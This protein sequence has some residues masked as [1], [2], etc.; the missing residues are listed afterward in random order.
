MN[1]TAQRFIDH[2]VVTDT[3]TGLAWTKTT[4]AKDV[5]YEQAEKAVAALGEGWRL[6]TADELSTLVDR[7][8]HEPAI[9]TDAFPDTQ[10]DIYWTSTPCAWNPEAAVWVVGFDLG[11]VNVLRRGFVGCVRAVRASQ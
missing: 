5:T 8:R 9:D 10:C 6:P 7:S 2:S 1:Q 11:I 3:K 4:I